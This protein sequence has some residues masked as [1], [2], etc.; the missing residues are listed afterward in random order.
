MAAKKNSNTEKYPDNS[1]DKADSGAEKPKTHF[2]HA[3]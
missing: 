3:I 2:G 1:A